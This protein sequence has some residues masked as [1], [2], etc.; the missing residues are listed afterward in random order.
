MPEALA[1]SILIALAVHA[2]LGVAFAAWFLTRGLAR[3]DPAAAHAPV[4]FR[5]LIAPGVVALW[6]VLLW[7]LR[8]GPLPSPM[9]E[10][11]T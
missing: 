9:S 5:L 8:S 10:A 3:L 2:G 11:R 6:P 4:T 7:K 1:S